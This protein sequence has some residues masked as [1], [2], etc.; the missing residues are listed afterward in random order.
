M[1]RTFLL[2]LTIQLANKALQKIAL[3]HIF[4]SSILALD[5]LGT[6][7][8]LDKFSTDLGLLDV[9]ILSDLSGHFIV[10]FIAIIQMI[11]I[12]TVNPIILIFAFVMI[13]PLYIW[14]SYCSKVVS[15]MK[16]M[17]LNEKGPVI[18]FFSESLNGLVQ[19]KN[20]HA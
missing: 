4:K 9:S 2:N 1:F 8:I 5:K 11:I 17:D 6:K 12:A 19:I 18:S 14:Y 16:D 7:G 15:I 13:I 10:S 3:S 20:M